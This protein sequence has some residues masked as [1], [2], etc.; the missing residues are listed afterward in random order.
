MTGYDRSMTHRLRHT[1]G[2]RIFAPIML[3]GLILLS[4]PVSAHAR[5]G[6]E[7]EVQPDARLLGYDKT[8]ALQDGSNALTYFLFVGLG[9]LCCGVLF[10]SSKRTHLD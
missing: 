4:L 8:V 3:A 1:P 5:P 10:I 2:R 7:D 6:D 9:V